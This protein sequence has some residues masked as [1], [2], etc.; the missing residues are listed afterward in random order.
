MEHRS[1]LFGLVRLHV[2]YHAS[3]E[4]VFGLEMIRELGRHGYSLSPGTLYPL[5]HGME[6]EGYLKSSE[7]QSGGRIRKFYRATR[8]GRAALKRARDQVREL[9]GELFDGQST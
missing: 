9:F 4:D 8:K 2:L 3:K 7:R 5:L 1:I 6:R